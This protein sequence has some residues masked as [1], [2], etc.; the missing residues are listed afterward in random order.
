LCVFSF[1]TADFAWAQI[2]TQQ[3]FETIGLPQLLVA[4][5]TLTGSG[6]TVTQVESAPSP[7]QFEVNPGSPGQPD[8]FFTWRSTVGTS[9]TWPNPV[10]S[11]SGH[12]GDVAED[13]YGGNTGIAPGIKHVYNYETS[14]FFPTVILAGAA[15]TSSV[16]NQS[17]GFGL[18][19]AEQDLAYD[20]YIARY[21]TIVVTGVG[22]GGPVYS[23][24]DCFNGIGAAAYGG[25]SSTG[26][27]AD[28]RCKPDLTAPAVETSFSTPLIAGA[29]AI[30]VQEARR[31]GINAVAAADSRTVKA[32][33]LTG[34]V[35]PSGWTHSTSV[36]LDY[37][38][39][40]G[41]MNIFNSYEEMI[42]GRQ[43]P[44]ASGLT[45]SLHPPLATG[46]PITVSRAWDYSGVTSSATA[47]GV[48]HYLISVGGSGDLI[49]TL[50]WNKQQRQKTIN[51][52]ALFVYGPGGTL[53][54][55]STSAV[56]NVQHIYLTGLAPGTYEI[57]VVK[58][59]GRIGSPGVISA[60]EIYS[61]AWDFE[62]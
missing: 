54:A 19:N 42:G 47:Y 10:G 9:G 50:A 26:P 14:D 58:Y 51:R 34:A 43:W 53:L 27:S 56:D 48:T 3:D 32:L 46:N 31:L 33:L 7:L 13:L 44:T 40:A 35:K 15:T 21:R 6:V 4:D 2:A 8:S 22:D 18:H 60:A 57:E 11:E 39:G 16:F 36:P 52:L 23:P 24:A 61:L 20:N 5:P 38:Y 49:T 28:G 29:A 17:F 62:R 25:G 55:S 37:H 1:L 45:T 41:I 59:P 30:L 12:A